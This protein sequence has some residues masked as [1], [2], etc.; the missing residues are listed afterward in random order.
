MSEEKQVLKCLYLV[1]FI[2][3]NQV[4]ELYVGFCNQNE[5]FENIK[6]TYSNNKKFIDVIN[7][8]LKMLYNQQNEN[9]NQ[10]TVQKSNTNLLDIDDGSNNNQQGNTNFFRR[11]F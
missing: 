6:M 4:N 11:Y 1:E 9:N 7:H 8:I 2:I 10:G 3:D 5:L